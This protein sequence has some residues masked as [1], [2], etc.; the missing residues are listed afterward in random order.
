MRACPWCSTKEQM[1]YHWP[2]PNV[3]EV[4]YY[5]NGS[6]KRIKFRQQIQQISRVFEQHPYTTVTWSNYGNSGQ[7]SI[8]S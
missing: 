5:E 3:E 8:R 7:S 4:E 1:I 2:C 6:V